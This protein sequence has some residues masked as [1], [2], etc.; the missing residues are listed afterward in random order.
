M[1]IEKKS[2]GEFF[3][4]QKSRKKKKKKKKKEKKKEKEENRV[5]NSIFVYY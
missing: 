2:W 5:Y 3:L 1:P 4:S